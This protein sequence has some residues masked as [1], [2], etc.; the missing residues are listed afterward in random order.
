MD[1][2][3]DQGEEACYD[4][5]LPEAI[6]RIAVEDGVMADVVYRDVAEE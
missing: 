4:R 1:Q 6:Y 3:I 2:G 5:R